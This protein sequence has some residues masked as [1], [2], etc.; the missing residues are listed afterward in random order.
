MGR[1]DEG[2][3]GAGA[4]EAEEAGGVDDD[5]D[6][7]QGAGAAPARGSSRHTHPRV[8]S[9]LEMDIIAI[10]AQSLNSSILSNILLVCNI[11]QI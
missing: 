3:S 5:D 1:N 7:C 8:L 11:V 2:D 4:G 9:N 6:R 10:F